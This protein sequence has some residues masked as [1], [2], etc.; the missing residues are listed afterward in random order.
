MTI[1][2][3]DVLNDEADY[4]VDELPDMR[5]FTMLLRGPNR[6]PVRFD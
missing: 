4:A 1:T 3:P 5:T 2:H 6:L